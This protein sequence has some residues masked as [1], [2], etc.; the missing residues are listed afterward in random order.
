MKK[1]LSKVNAFLAVGSLML[2]AEAANAAGTTGT[3]LQPTYQLLDDLANGYGKQIIIL[4]GFIA[5]MIALVALR[6]FTP[7]LGYIGFVIFAG[8]G[9]ALGVG[10]AG[11]MI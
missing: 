5:A 11:A 1:L 4:T 7:M 2:L 6:G 3:V 9:L 8:V 10:V